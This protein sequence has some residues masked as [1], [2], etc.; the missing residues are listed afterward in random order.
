MSFFGGARLRAV[1]VAWGGGGDD[2]TTMRGR[3]LFPGGGG[4]GGGLSLRLALAVFIRRQAA[5]TFTPTHVY[6][7]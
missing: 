6:F 2:L 3:N 5:Q 1:L 4:A 7:V